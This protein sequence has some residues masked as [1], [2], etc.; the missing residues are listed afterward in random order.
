MTT[1]ACVLRSGG[2]YSPE[3]V[4][5]L[6]RGVARHLSL[7]HRFVCLSDVDVPC[8]RIP[9]LHGWPGWWSKI[10]LF[11]PGLLT[12]PA[13]YLDLDCIITGP[14]DGLFRTS[15]T[16]CDDFLRPG[17]HNSSVMSWHGDYS[18]IYEAMQRD[19]EGVM[20]AYT[21]RKDGRIGDQAMI[22]D[23]VTPETF[24]A[25]RIVSYRVSA[26]HTVPE[27]ASVVTFHGAVKQDTAG[28]WVSKFWK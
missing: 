4:A 13:L 15:L 9:L 27:G 20:A 23:Q 2:R 26:R 16:M 18:H 28:G 7:P 24:P 25:G 12:G 5:K 22:E 14:L 17:L 10:E 1:V 6:Q 3:W 8:E 11:R 19:P 21:R